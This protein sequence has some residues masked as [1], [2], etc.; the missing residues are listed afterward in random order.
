M[1]NQADDTPEVG[2]GRADD[3]RLARPPHPYLRRNRLAALSLL[4]PALRVL[5]VA[6]AVVASLNRGMR[7]LSASMGRQAAD[8]G[9]VLWWTAMVMTTL[10]SD[11]WPR[12]AEGPALCF[13]L[14]VYALAVWRYITAS[15]ATFLVGRDAEDDR[16][17]LAGRQ[18]IEALRR[19]IAALRAELR[20]SATP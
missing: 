9:T 6:R 12:T 14:A 10:G 11:Y 1:T 18:S 5:G 7:S 17:E 15:L 2:A 13:L 3:A 19:D 8:Y 16:A 20:P 4:A